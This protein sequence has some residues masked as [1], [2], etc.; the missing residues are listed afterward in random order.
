MPWLIP[1]GVA[2]EGYLNSLPWEAQALWDETSPIHY[3]G[4]ASTPTLIQHG[5]NDQVVPVEN[6][7]EFYRGLKDMGVTA[8]AVIFKDSGHN[9]SKPKEKLGW[10]QQNQ[11]WFT[12]YLWESPCTGEVVN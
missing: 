7:Y 6:A 2:N 10:M 11:D 9:V 4:N 12:H 8:R 1:A 3:V 5:D